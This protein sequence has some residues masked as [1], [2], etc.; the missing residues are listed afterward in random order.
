MEIESKEESD[1]LATPFLDN[2]IFIIAIPDI[3]RKSIF[4]LNK[5]VQDLNTH[6]LVEIQ[7]YHYIGKNLKH[8]EIFKIVKKIQTKNKTF[9]FNS[10]IHTHHDK[11]QMEN[12]VCYFQPLF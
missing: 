4:V 6:V 10:R 8:K 5:N 11:K 3:S 7:N 9:K 2:G 12:I 1:Q